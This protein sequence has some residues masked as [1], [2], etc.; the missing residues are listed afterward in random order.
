M[1]VKLADKKFYQSY[2]IGEKIGEHGGVEI[3]EARLTAE[4]RRSQRWYEVT[5]LAYEPSSQS[6]VGMVVLYRVQIGGGGTGV[7]IAPESACASDLREMSMRHGVDG[8][9]ALVVGSSH[10][11]ASHRGRGLGAALYV[12]AAAMAKKLGFALVA[13]RCTYEGRT[14]PDAERVW[15][16]Q[17]FRAQVEVASESG[18]VGVYR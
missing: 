8:K 9:R 4:A 16:S 18:L 11:T 7:E 14:S 2:E 5:A 10:I 3:Y 17:A 13:D 1:R 12:A 15:A 6:F